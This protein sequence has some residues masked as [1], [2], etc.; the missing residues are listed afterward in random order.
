MEELRKK[1]E[2]R[3][4]STGEYFNEG[5]NV[6]KK[7]I[8]NQMPLIIAMIVLSVLGGFAQ[9]V[10]IGNMAIHIIL[11]KKIVEMIENEESTLSREIIVKIIKVI[12]II[13]VISMFM[14]IIISMIS[15]SSTNIYMSGNYE[16]ALR[17]LSRKI[18]L[19]TSALRIIG[20]II[21]LSIFP[22]VIYM[23]ITRNVTLK[24][25]F[26][27]NSEIRN[28]NRLR[29]LIPV[30]TITL[31]GIFIGSIPALFFIFPPFISVIVFTLIGNMLEI[32]MNSIH[33][34]VFLNVEYMNKKNNPDGLQSE[35]NN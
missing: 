11:I 1:L 12:G 3:Y 29:L 7:I 26:K 13:I 21:Y 23:Y 22:Y 8:K 18:F 5:V 34:V 31:I 6:S 27:I 10:L 32:Y 14:G 33:S 35:I 9:I 4:L 19:L 2:E 17:E 20:V 28:G 25:A 15:L 16:E 30:I 24:E